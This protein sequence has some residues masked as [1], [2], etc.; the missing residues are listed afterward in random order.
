MLFI[1]KI[2]KDI[3]NQFKKAV[4]IIC[5]WIVYYGL[6]LLLGTHLN[7]IK[8][9]LIIIPVLLTSISYGKW[10]GLC[11]GAISYIS[12]HY[13][14]IALSLTPVFS[15]TA[16]LSHTI[17]L[18]I[19]GFCFGYLAETTVSL[20]R[21]MGL[22]LEA[23]KELQK[24]ENRAIQFANENQSLLREVNHRVLNNFSVLNSV[25]NFIR[26]KKSYS[27]EANE[28]LSEISTRIS[29][30]A[31][32]QKIIQDESVYQLPLKIVLEKVALSVIKGHAF[33]SSIPI[34]V[35]CEH[36]LVSGRIGSKISIILCELIINSIKY[37]NA[38]SQTNIK[39][40][41]SK[42]NNWIEIIYAD[43]GPGYPQEILKGEGTGVGLI[44]VSSIVNLDL[45]GKLK[46]TSS[47]GA[48]TNIKFPVE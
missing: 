18:S 7:E 30:L 29:S 6:T 15:T 16:L 14:W 12:S 27:E 45:R 20:K 13:C 4:F 32:L 46:L 11:S 17:A 37:V 48:I 24:R 34:T 41:C 2:K 10:A 40:S 43:N 36:I 26:T 23:E 44:L 33:S 1:H 39:I 38:N 19:L 35:D 21:E 8:L 25:I 3:M 9:S 47:N 31:E 5:I 28:L 42:Q 22:R